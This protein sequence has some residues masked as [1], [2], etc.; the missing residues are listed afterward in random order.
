MQEGRIT[1]GAVGTR[2]RPGSLP[3]SNRSACGDGPPA[4][5]SGTGASDTEFR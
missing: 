1:G 3:A 5:G 2:V 4:Q